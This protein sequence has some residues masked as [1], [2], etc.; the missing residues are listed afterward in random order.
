MVNS[1]LLSLSAELADIRCQTHH[2]DEEADARQRDESNCGV[3]DQIIADSDEL[4]L[5]VEFCPINVQ[6][7]GLRIQLK[8]FV[9]VVPLR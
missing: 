8:L 1:C 3:L 9:P 6:P 2:K 7:R 4:E 5:V